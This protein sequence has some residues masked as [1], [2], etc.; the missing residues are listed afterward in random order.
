MT[1]SSIYGEKETLEYAE[2][3]RD[4]LLRLPSVTQVELSGVRD[5]EIA[6]EV[7][8]DTLRQYDLRLSDISSAISNSSTDVSAGNLKTEG[9]DVLIR[10][11][12]K[13]IAKTNLL[14]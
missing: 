13:L 11:K 14:T 8:Q 12:V 9:G 4:E 2:T 3:V 10:S 7:S 5:Y 6:I 1:V